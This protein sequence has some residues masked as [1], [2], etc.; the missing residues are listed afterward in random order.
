MSEFCNIL[1]QLRE[2]KGITQKEIAKILGISQAAYS[3]YEKG[4]REPKYEMLEKIA[5]IFDIRPSFLM[6]WDDCNIKINQSIKAEIKKPLEIKKLSETNLT[7]KEVEKLVSNISA[8]IYKRVQLENNI[9]KINTTKNTDINAIHFDN[10]EYTEKEL[11]E[12]KQFAGFLI[13]K[14]IN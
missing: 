6:G 10:T 13:W 5:D 14:R 4:Q 7:Q 12:I 1:K 9:E 3:L 8:L 2:E 11:E